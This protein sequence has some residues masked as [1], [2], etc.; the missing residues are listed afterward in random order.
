LDAAFTQLTGN[1]YVSDASWRYK[2]KFS[3]A[4][5]GNGWHFDSLH[6][7]TVP[8]PGTMVLLGTGLI[9]LACKERKLRKKV[10]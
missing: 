5:D 3:P 8:E 4:A 9:G 6:M 2:V 7:A 1:S 10:M